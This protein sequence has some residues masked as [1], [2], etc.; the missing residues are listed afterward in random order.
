MTKPVLVF[1]DNEVKFD[2]KVAESHSQHILYC[3]IL[4]I[5]VYCC[6]KTDTALSILKVR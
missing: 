1:T 5:Y 6:N 2:V 4:H 3:T